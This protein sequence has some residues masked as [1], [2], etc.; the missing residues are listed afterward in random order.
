MNLLKLQVNFVPCVQGP[1]QDEQ[2]TQENAHSAEARFQLVA[3]KGEGD[4]GAGD[5]SLPL[6]CLVASRLSCS[7]T[8]TS[9]HPSK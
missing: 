7:S 9:G 2:P 6:R 8:W 5:H 1:R 4:E 3:N